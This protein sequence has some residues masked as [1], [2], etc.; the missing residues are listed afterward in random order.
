MITGEM[1][2]SDFL[3]ALAAKTSTPGGG[4]A[5]A[6]TGAQAA[7]LL[8]MVIRFT[9][10]NKK[11]AGVAEELRQLLGQSEKLRNDLVALADH[12]V[13]AFTAVAACYSMPKT[14][15]EEKASRAAAMQLA[16]Q[17]ATRVPM[18]IAEQCLLVL[19][20]VE[21]VAAKG[22]ANVVSDAATALYL[23]HAG[24]QSALVNVN[25]NL[26]SMKDAAFIAEFTAK[27]DWVL[28]DA[29]E[30]FALAKA[31]CEQTLGIML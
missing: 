19:R 15:E 23:A 3:E 25:I 12:D 21:P 17:G 7:A 20:L 28:S 1:T 24:L 16:L 22:N 4:G 31:A 13:E 8:S 26:K 14:T 18:V 10:D 11:Y 9:V 5:A 29:T 2:I 6:L 27:R 30:T